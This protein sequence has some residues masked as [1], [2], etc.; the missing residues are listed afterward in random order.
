VQILRFLIF[1]PLKNNAFRCSLAGDRVRKMNTLVPSGRTRK[2]AI[3]QIHPRST[4]Y[5]PGEIRFGLR[6]FQNFTGNLKKH[7][8]AIIFFAGAGSSPG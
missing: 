8:K 3:P 7:E 5:P 1:K 6:I 2:F 4:H